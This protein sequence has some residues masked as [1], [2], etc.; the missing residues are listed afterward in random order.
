MLIVLKVLILYEAFRGLAHSTHSK[1]YKQLLLLFAL[2]KHQLGLFL[3][4]PISSSRS[5]QVALVV[6]NL[7]A[8]TG[9]V[10]DVGLITESGSSPGGEQGNSLQYSCLEIP[11]DRGAWPSTALR[12]TKNLIQL[13]GLSTHAS[14]WYALTCS[15]SP[16]IMSCGSSESLSDSPSQLQHVGAQLLTEQDGA[17]DIQE[18]VPLRKR[19]MNNSL[20]RGSDTR[21]A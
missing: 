13:K 19:G 14:Y 17:S 20:C 18:F 21:P 6:K 8:S 9:N 10:R 11:M 4:V 15:P 3:I 16:V 1:G 7:P 2:H 5:S 12:V